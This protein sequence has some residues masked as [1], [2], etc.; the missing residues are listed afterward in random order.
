MSSKAKILV[1]SAAGKTGL[2]VSMRL[3]SLGHPIR[4]IVRRDDARAAALRSAGA[5]VMVGDVYAVP[6]M[7]RAMK[8][9]QRAYHCAPTAPNGQLFSGVFATAAVE[10]RVEH[11]VTLGQWL[12]SPHH[13]SHFTREVW[14]SEQMLATLPDTT[15]TIVN[16]G[17]FADNY[18]MVMGMAAQ[19]G[20]MPMPLGDGDTAKNAPPSNEAMAAVAAAALADPA[21]HAG[22]TY[23]P[24]GPELLSPNQIADAMGQ[25]LGRRVRYMPVSEKMFHK[26]LTANPPGNFSFQAL[27]QLT[28]YAQEYRR[29]TFAVGG[30]TDVVQTVGGLPAESFVETARREAQ[31]RPETRRTLGNRMA[32]IW[33][34][35]KTGMTPAPNLPRILR[36]ADL[37]MPADA[38]LAIDSAEWRSTHGAAPKLVKAA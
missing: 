38:T 8:G 12:S 3:L 20:V 18:F 33:G 6:D 7:R 34:F 4:A 13:P 19:L 31:K 29:G 14:L 5:E 35:M 16:P 30:A 26:A 27:S 9:V 17:W 2:Q 36:H 32:G 10:E 37:H 15:L 1:T 22:K 11:V 21:T 23:R 28:L 25:A 24:T